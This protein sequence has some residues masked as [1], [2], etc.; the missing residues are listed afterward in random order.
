MCFSIYIPVT[1]AYPL[2]GDVHKKANIIHKMHVAIGIV[3]AT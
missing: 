2:F 3:Y 1:N